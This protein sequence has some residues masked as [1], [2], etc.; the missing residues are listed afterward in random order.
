MATKFREIQPEVDVNNKSGLQWM[1]G[2][3]R[4]VWGMDDQQ[5]EKQ[6]E[7]H[8]EAQH[9]AG[10]AFDGCRVAGE[11][12]GQWFLSR[13]LWHRKMC[14][15]QTSINWQA[16]MIH[17]WPLFT[18]L[19]IVNQSPPI[20][21][22]VATDRLTINDLVGIRLP[23]TR[24]SISHYFFNHQKVSSIHHTINQPSWTSIRWY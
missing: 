3:C 10:C 5:Q 16:S 7:Q 2:W 14:K 18:M 11:R 6:K 12:L 24:P 21:H 4:M 15:D 23:S 8:G 13:E 19:I 9:R 20:D 1:V 22:Q 17:G